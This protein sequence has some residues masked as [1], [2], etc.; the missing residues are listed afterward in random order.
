MNGFA[1]N[2]WETKPHN[3]QV[4]KLFLDGRFECEQK[5]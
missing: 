5:Y 4:R 1:V 2:F 3:S